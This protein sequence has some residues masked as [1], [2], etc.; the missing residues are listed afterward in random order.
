M[1]HLETDTF[2]NHHSWEKE[3]GRFTVEYYIKVLSYLLLDSYG[4]SETLRVCWIIDE[5]IMYEQCS[6]STHLVSNWY[7]YWVMQLFFCS[8]VDLNYIWSWSLLGSVSCKRMHWLTE[9]SRLHEAEV[10]KYTEIYLKQK[11]IEDGEWT[12]G[13]CRKYCD[14]VCRN[15]KLFKTEYVWLFSF[16]LESF[17]KRTDAPEEETSC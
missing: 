10:E 4:L 2:N 14:M 16:R 6:F 13:I 7:I 17:P 15:E 5:L 3:R 8:D 9:L 11:H 1:Q 12:P